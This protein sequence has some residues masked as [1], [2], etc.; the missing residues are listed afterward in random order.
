MGTLI[1]DIPLKVLYDNKLLSSRAFTVC[2]EINRDPTFNEII[3]FYDEHHTF[4]K[5][6]NCGTNT[7]NELIEICKHSIEIYHKLEHV[8]EH[9]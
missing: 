4:I 6:R 7:N 1:N 2:R 8:I 9:H 3:N 5:V